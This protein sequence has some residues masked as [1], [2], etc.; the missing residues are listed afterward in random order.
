MGKLYLRRGQPDRAAPLFRTVLTH[1]R[2][3]ADQRL[4]A[5]W[6]LGVA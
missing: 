3:T 4:V 5:A 6:E 1:P 2:A